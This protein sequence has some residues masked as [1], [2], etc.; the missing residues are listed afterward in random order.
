LRSRRAGS[1]FSANLQHQ[2]NDAHTLRLHVQHSNSDAQNQ[3]IG[4]FDLPER[5][6]SRSDADGEFRLGHEAT[7]H[8]TLWSEFRLQIRWRSSQS[9][10]ASDATTVRVLDAFTSGGAQVEGGRRSHTLNVGEDLWFTVRK[11]HKIGVGRIREWRRLPWRRTA[12]SEW[13]VHVRQPRHVRAGVPT[14]FTQRVV[15]NP[16]FEYSTY[17]TNWYVQ[18]DYRVRNDLLLNLGLRGDAQSHL[19]SRW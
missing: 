1:G 2:V 3:G 5:A 14:T 12:Q 15:L 16:V 4:S 8:R 11:V 13:H 17:R 19:A 7:L 18:D 6:F 10:S 9:T